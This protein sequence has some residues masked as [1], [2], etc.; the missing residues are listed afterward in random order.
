MRV[1]NCDPVLGWTGD[2][3]TFQGWFQ[4]D[5]HVYWEETTLSLLNTN[6]QK[7]EGKYLQPSLCQLCPTP[8][9]IHT[10]PPSLPSWTAAEIHS[11]QWHTISFWDTLLYME[12]R[13]EV[14]STRE[15]ALKS[16]EQGCFP[17]V[18][19]SDPLRL[20]VDPGKE[21]EAFRWVQVT[22]LPHTST[23]HLFSLCL[24]GALP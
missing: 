12:Y 15:S 4:H 20:V 1:L 3:G 2:T 21:R 8:I 10:S 17:S 14:P 22:E 19:L 11:K 24:V 7:I 5:K 23:S 6:S 16:S 9:P 18:S 13:E